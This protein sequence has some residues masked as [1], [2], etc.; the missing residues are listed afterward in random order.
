[1]SDNVKILI[2]NIDYRD[3]GKLGG[4]S[5]VGVRQVEQGVNYYNISIPHKCSIVTTELDDRLKFFSIN[6]LKMCDYSIDILVDNSKRNVGE[7]KHSLE[8]LGIRAASWTDIGR[9]MIAA[10]SEI[11]SI[12]IVYNKYIDI[13]E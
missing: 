2:N 5:Y 6:M 12:T 7:L 8:M 9:N 4:G 10:L 13:I 3:C 1:M 11:N